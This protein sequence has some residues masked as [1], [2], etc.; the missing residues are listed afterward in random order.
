M[1][2]AYNPQRGWQLEDRIRVLI[3][4]FD[5]L[6]REISKECDDFNDGCGERIGQLTFRKNTVAA[7]IVAAAAVLVGR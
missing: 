2:A 7:E 6:N 4:D 1:T 3:A 5:Q